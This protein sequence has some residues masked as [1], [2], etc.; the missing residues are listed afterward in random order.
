MRMQSVH[1]TARFLPAI[2]AAA[3]LS[4]GS[5][6]AV[7][8]ALTVVPVSVSMPP[9]Q[10]A[11]ALTIINQGDRETTFQVHAF[12][13]D[14]SGP[15]ERLLPTEELVASPA[16]VT[17]APGS[18]QVVQIALDRPAQR[19][20]ASYRILLDQAPPPAAPGVVRI[21]LRQSIPVFVAPAAQTASRLQWRIESGGGQAVLVAMNA[22]S[23]H[24]RVRDLAVA[25]AAGTTS[26]VDAVAS[27]YILPG[28]TR[29]WQ[30]LTPGLAAT[31]GATVRLTGLAV[32]GPID[33]RV[34]VSASR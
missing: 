8:Q 1:R 9:G 11:A 32:A 30:L 21:A 22:G 33:Q 12:A 15:E 23:R 25:G 19:K 2:T 34:T 14:Q 17:M 26:G 24:E 13:W 27:P 28:A 6:A 18:I 10:M 16:T 20:E 31:P 7:A 3:L 29:R 4:V 5:S